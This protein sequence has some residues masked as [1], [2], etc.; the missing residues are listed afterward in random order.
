MDFL[1][2]IV[3]IIFMVV[4]GVTGV[5]NFGNSDYM[6]CQVCQVGGVM[7]MW[8]LLTAIDI[9]AIMSLDRFMYIKKPNEYEKWTTIPRLAIVF[10]TTWIITFFLSILPLF[11][12]GVIGFLE[13]YGACIPRLKSL[14]RLGPTY[15]YVGFLTLEMIFPL[16]VF[17][18][19]N[20]WLL[21]VIRKGI[22]KLDDST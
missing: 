10:V 20:A 15:I 22:K 18:V 9:I 17:V 8:L 13:V 3:I 19:S 11:G 12:S 4:P 21:Y 1:T 14:T 16:G 6:L 2:C 5:Y 7:V